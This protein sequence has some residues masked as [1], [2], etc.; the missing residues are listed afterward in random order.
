MW[1]GE[2][3]IVFSRYQRNYVPACNRDF[4]FLFSSFFFFFFLGGVGGGGVSVLMGTSFLFAAL[5]SLFK[6]KEEG[7]G[8]ALTLLLSTP[9]ALSDLLQDNNAKL[10]FP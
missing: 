1:S 5:S 8:V 10:N 4:L 9:P 6:P 3:S 7:N 2:D